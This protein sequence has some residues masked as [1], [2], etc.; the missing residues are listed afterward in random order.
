MATLSG[1]V[2]G[3]IA[4]GAGTPTKYVGQTKGLGGIS[5]AIGR[6]VKEQERFRGEMDAQTSALLSRQ[7]PG[8]TPFTAQPYAPAAESRL[9]ALGQAMPGVRGMTAP[10]LPNMSPR[11]AS[12]VARSRMD[13]RDQ[14][15]STA[16]QGAEE[17]RARTLGEVDFR[18]RLL[19]DI[20]KQR[21]G[22]YEQEQNTRGMRGIAERN[23][24]S[25]LND[26]GLALIKSGGII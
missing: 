6:Q 25:T 12:A 13:A 24:G 23:I 18:R 8:L 9:A 2:P 21:A 11:L 3:L 19:G 15:A 20:A 7:P 1:L 16:M 26:I 10:G 17:Q 14:A 22:L 4:M 5:G